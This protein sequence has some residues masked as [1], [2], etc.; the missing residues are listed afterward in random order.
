[1]TINFNLNGKCGVYLIVN[2]LN[3]NR[4]VGSSK[5]L[6][7]RLY[8]HFYSLEHQT[9]H[10]KHLQSAYNKYGECNFM[11][12]ILEFCSEEHQ[13]E[14]EQ[15]YISFMKPEYNKSEYV[16]ANTGREV[17]ESTRTKISDTLKGRYRN[18]EIVTYKQNRVWE[19]VWLYDIQNWELVGEFDYPTLALKH[20]NYKGTG[21]KNFE[22]SILQDKYIMSKSKFNDTLELQNYVFEHMYKSRGTKGCYIVTEKDGVIMY[23]R[24]LIDCANS[25]GSSKSTLSKHPNASVDNPYYVKTGYKFYYSNSFK[26]SPSVLETHR[27]KESKYDEVLREDVV[28]TD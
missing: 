7:G 23:H 15:S 22:N 14:L 13:Y 9:H 27:C 12:C 11:Y 20:I 4:Y 18:G 17:E 10:N 21:Y 26:P 5:N 1:M 8:D 19:T 25:I 24:T 28:L 6:Y 3:G 16:I 2:T